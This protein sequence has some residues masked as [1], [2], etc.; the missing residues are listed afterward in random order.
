MGESNRLDRGL[1][2]VKDHPAFPALDGPETIHTS[3]RCP[4]FGGK[5][6]ANRSFILARQDVVLRKDR[7]IIKGNV[8]T[9]SSSSEFVSPAL[10]N[11][12]KVGQCV[13]QVERS[14]GLF[15]SRESEYVGFDALRGILVIEEHR[16]RPSVMSGQKIAA[17]ATVPM[18]ERVPKG[19]G[20]AVV[21]MK[22]SNPLRD[23]I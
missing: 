10:R 4:Q 2:D 3:E 21:K 23:R 8:T 1:S 16:L 22:E 9:G 19:H 14:Y 17:G 5:Q 18:V 12:M 6:A 7:D 11:Q 15:V 20:E 13:F